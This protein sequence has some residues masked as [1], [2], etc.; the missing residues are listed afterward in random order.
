MNQHKLA[1]EININLFTPLD[2]TGKVKTIIYSSWGL[3]K[4]TL[5][6]GIETNVYLI[7]SLD[8]YEFKSTLRFNQQKSLSLE[9]LP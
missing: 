8:T 6:N 9:L 4:V 2:V 5:N 3:W 7:I 1:Y